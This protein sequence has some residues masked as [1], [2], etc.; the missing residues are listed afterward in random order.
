M[1]FL[2]IKNGNKMLKPGK[3]YIL[4]KKNYLILSNNQVLS[5]DGLISFLDSKHILAKYTND[6]EIIKKLSEDWHVRFFI[7]QNSNCPTEI[8]AQLSI[9][10][11]IENLKFNR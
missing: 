5:S 10:Y 4:N 11:A 1:L 3:L 8:L 2:K 6:I 7:M 9:E